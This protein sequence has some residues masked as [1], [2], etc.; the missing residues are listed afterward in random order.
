MPSQNH[1]TRWERW[2]L[3][4]IQVVKALLRKPSY[5]KVMLTR[6]RW[7]KYESFIV[8]CVVVSLS[9]VSECG[10]ALVHHLHAGLTAHQK[11]QSASMCLGKFLNV[12]LWKG[13]TCWTLL[14]DLC[15]FFFREEGDKANQLSGKEGFKGSLMYAARWDCRWIVM[16]VTD[17]NGA[18]PEADKRREVVD[19]LTTEKKVCFESTCRQC[20]SGYWTREVESRLKRRFAQ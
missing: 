6:I 16:G 20:G 10:W 17:G 8:S 14:T 13:H 15:W 7:C 4:I 2:Q 12:L 19:K 5:C 9:V 11:I 3:Q 1:C 18:Q